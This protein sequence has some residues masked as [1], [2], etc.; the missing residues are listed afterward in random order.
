LTPRPERV[1]DVVFATSPPELRAAIV[2]T[3]ELVAFVGRALEPEAPPASLRDRILATMNA[4]APRRAL[5]VV[6]MIVD[7]LAPGSLL[8]VPRAREIVP[9]LQKRIAAAR[10]AGIPV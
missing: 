3:R 1:E 9:A 4:R 7:H 8:E 6:D 2:G 10:T 5:L